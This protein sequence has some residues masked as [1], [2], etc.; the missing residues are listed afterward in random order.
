MAR[1]QA[2]TGVHGHSGANLLRAFKS[3]NLLMF[4]FVDDRNIRFRGIPLSVVLGKIYAGICP[5]IMGFMAQAYKG[6]YENISEQTLQHVAWELK[7]V[8]NYC[9]RAIL[10]ARENSQ[11]V[12]P[13]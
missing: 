8:I 5:N 13:S 11:S 1:T 4:I 3:D 6:V 9:I 10:N 2:R 7:E 12:A